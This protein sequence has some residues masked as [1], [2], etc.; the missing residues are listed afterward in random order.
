MAPAKKRRLLA[1]A[2]AAAASDA[3]NDGTNVDATTNDMDV[4]MVPTPPAPSS[5]YADVADATMDISHPPPPPSSSSSSSDRKRVERGIVTKLLDRHLHTVDSIRRDVSDLLR[6][7]AGPRPPAPSTATI[8]AAE[9]EENDDAFENLVISSS[10]SVSKLKY[11]QR[12]IALRVEMSSIASRRSREA[13]DALVSSLMNVAYERDYLR[14]EI[15]SI[16]KYRAYSLERMALGE[17]GIDPSEFDMGA[18][19]GGGG[20]GVGGGGRSTTTTTKTTI[21]S[22]SNAPS[23]GVPPVTAVSSSFEEGEEMEGEE[24]GEG[25]RMIAAEHSGGDDG[26]ANAGDVACGITTLEG[27]IDAYLFGDDDGTMATYERRENNDMADARRGRSHR[28][29]SEHAFVLE[30]LTSDLNKRSTLVERLSKAKLELGGLI[31]RRDELMGLL[32]KLPT[33]L[34]E[35]RRA[36]EEL[37]SLFSGGG[38]VGVWRDVLMDVG[39]DDDIDIDIDIDGG[40]SGRKGK[41]GTTNKVTAANLLVCRP[42]FD[43]T[44][45]FRLAKSNLPSPLYVLY[46]QLAG[47]IDAWSSLETLGKGGGVAAGGIVNAVV[48]SP[49]SSS[50]S[51]FSPNIAPRGFVGAP[52]MDVTA[53]PPPERGGGGGWSVVLTLTPS[54]IVPSE[55]PSL[56]GKT[57]SNNPRSSSSTATA[58]AVVKISFS[59][60]NTRGVVQAMMADGGDGYDGLLDNMFPGDDGLFNPNVSLLLLNHDEGGNVDDTREGGVEDRPDGSGTIDDNCKGGGAGKPYYW[61]QV[62]GGLDFPPP[63]FAMASPGSARDG[64]GHEGDGRVDAPFPIEICTRAV[65]RQLLRRIRARRTLAAILEYLGK[66]GNLHPLPIHPAMRGEGGGVVVQPQ[67]PKAKLHSWGEDSRPDRSNRSA[68]ASAAKKSY[69]ALIKRKASTLKATVVIDAHN[70]PAEPP[71]WS[72]LNEDGSLGTLSSWGEES[73]GDFSL[74]QQQNSNNT[75]PPPSLFDAALHRIECRV[76]LELDMYVR[77]DVEATYDWILIHQL[78]DIVSCWDEVMNVMDGNNGG[79]VSKGR[80]E[81]PLNG[82]TRRGKDRR[83]VEFGERSPFFW[84]RNGL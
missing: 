16:G 26:D 72:L 7:A 80:N 82:R 46:V 35:L 34:D 19:G 66:R 55:V 77:Q 11:L 74:Q 31:K 79:A 30:K 39:D 52:G 78:A 41:R 61:C 33:K 84:Y 51:S 58:V 59:L 32:D 22:T 4:A 13:C 67:S 27:A 71:L 43:R 47:Y 28:D 56:L 60:D 76:N 83:I 75:S 73:G 2:D 6:L 68:P 24:D 40:G 1:A 12:R 29:P 44:E 65:F 50:S 48:A 54:E 81:V 9:G 17:L 37:N 38:G 3:I 23:R 14:H 21:A 20:G 15:A 63:P 69:T 25:G 42:K 36:G 53:T 70:Y 5:S 57:N 45:R 62:L 10:I 8:A 49:P 18:G 64:A